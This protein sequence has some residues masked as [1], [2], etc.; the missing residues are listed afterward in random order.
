MRITSDLVYRRWVSTNRRVL[1]PPRQ[2]D[3]YEERT[4]YV[5]KTTLQDAGDG[6]FARR[7]LAV[8]TLV[9]FYNGVRLG[10]GEDKIAIGSL[11][12]RGWKY[13]EQEDSSATSAW[14]NGSLR[15]GC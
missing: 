15:D 7:D 10:P 1:C 13:E 12:E 2:V 4:V 6:L 11:V 5:D 9:A 8:D 3:V 14:L